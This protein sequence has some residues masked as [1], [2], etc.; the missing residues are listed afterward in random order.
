MTS[1]R[2]L[3]NAWDIRAKKQ[4]GQ[5]FLSDRSTAEM[6]VTRSGIS[7][8]DVVLEIGAGLGAITIPV[9]RIARAVY[10]IEIDPRLIDHLNTELLT[11]NIANV[12]LMEKSIFHLDIEELGRRLG[13]KIVVMGNLPYNVSSQILVKLINSRKTVNRAVL[14]FQK[15]LA[16][17]ITA[18]PGGK[19]YGR[20]TV[21][22]NY[23]ADLNKLATID[24]A[25][26]FPKPKVDSTVLE[27]KFKNLL[28]DR[29]YN[30]EFLFR[31][32]K[33]AF[34]RRRKTLK[35]A[36]AGSQ[37]RVTGDTALHALNLAGID[38]VRRAETLDVSE[39]VALSNC[40][41][42]MLQSENHPE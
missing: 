17:R 31:V 5:N 35:N 42:G 16:Q 26:F 15:E 28:Q 11:H 25:L 22:L 10:A 30:E 18:Q 2:I 7:A 21:M 3:L 19:D 23:C 24:A 34:G 8:D 38:P 6:I 20:L 12:S 13:H 32:I 39:F 1:P 40:L 14:M 36:L 27:I 4:L 41:E 9:A 29:A 33:A 37:L